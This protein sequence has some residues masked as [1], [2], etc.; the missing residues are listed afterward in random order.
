M[1]EVSI[2]SASSVDANAIRA[3]IRAAYAV[4][5]KTLPDL[6]DVAAG[7][8]EDIAGGRVWIAEQG[9]EITG[10]LIGGMVGEHWHLANVAVSPDHGSKGIGRALIAFAVVQAKQQG[11]HEMALATHRAMPGN[12]ALYERLGWEV[13]GEVGNNIMMR[14][15]TGS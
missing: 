13:S 10:C 15:S 7:V 8:A 9:S 6:P 1:R 12:V 2:R 5:A 14:R 4:W 11:A 3:V